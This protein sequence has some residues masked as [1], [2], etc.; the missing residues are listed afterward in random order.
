MISSSEQLIED[1]NE[2]FA[3]FLF[4]YSEIQYFGKIPVFFIRVNCEEEVLRRDWAHMVN[5]IGIHF[6]TTLENEFEVWNIYL[7]FILTKRISD[8]LKY[9]IENDT[10]SSRKIVIDVDTSKDS[11]IAQHIRNDDLV[12]G[13]REISDTSLQHNPAIWEFLKGKE[14]K[15]RTTEEDRKLFDKILNKIKIESN[16]I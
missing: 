14:A 9:Q 4:E 11:I 7:F 10:F 15:K 5:Y 12:F 3:D 13:N 1:L 8:I 2:K 6:Q 16:E